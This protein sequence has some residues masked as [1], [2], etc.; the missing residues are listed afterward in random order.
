LGI[1]TPLITPDREFLEK[2][3]FPFLF[4]SERR[5]R[6]LF[7]GTDI[8][9]WHYDTYFPGRSFF[10]I[11]EDSSKAR[12]GSKKF[13]TIGS[14]CFLSKYYSKEEFD[15]VI[16]NGLIGFGLN[17][18]NDVDLALREAFRVLAKDGLLIVG[19]NNAPHRINFVLEDLP[20]YQ[21]FGIY[22]DR[23]EVNPYNKH[24]FDFLVKKSHVGNLDGSKNLADWEPF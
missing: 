22:A 23:I 9:T 16:F 7:A 24:T 10:T 8:Y 17:T 3:I 12:Y 6:I 13:H 5:Q 1:P 14:V 19:W 2:K 4:A 18:K 11:D 20:G 21:S 15:V